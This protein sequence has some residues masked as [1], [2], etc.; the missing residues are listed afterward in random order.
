L[1]LLPQVKSNQGILAIQVV[2]A[3]LI[4][5]GW[6]IVYGMLSQVKRP[7]TGVL[8]VGEGESAREIHQLLRSPFSPY[9]VKGYLDN[10]FGAQ[11]RAE[12]S[13]YV[14]GSLDQLTEIAVQ[15]GANTAILAI[16]RNRPYWAT[17]KI[18]EARLQGIEVIEMPSIYEKLTGRVPVEHI[19]DQWLL[20]SDGF[21]LLSR[22]YV[23]RIKR[24][25]DFGVSGLLL[26]LASPIMALTALAIR[27][28]SPGP[29]LYRQ[30]RVGKGGKVFSVFKFRS[31][32]VD[33]EAQGIK[34]AQKRDPRVTRV[35]RI[36]RMFRIDELPQIWN[37]FKGDMSL[38]GPRPERPVFVEQLASKIPYYNIRHTVAPGITGWAQVRYPYGASLDDAL[39][40]L[41]YELYY[42]KNMS[43]LLDIR[44]LLKTIG[45]VLLGEGAR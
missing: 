17:R 21:H 24:L 40:K 14:L 7:K 11:G 12:R 33:A 3:G 29:I 44:I 42:I 25:V 39:H 16:P 4:L 31:M 1:Y 28:E 23:Q 37:V 6:R 35:G 15:V 30:E 19:E 41:E 38:V 26:T 20:F 9:K 8:V 34:W 5:T 45:V 32:T 36:I 18:L 43:I 2:L 27:I 10:G 22:G 13:P